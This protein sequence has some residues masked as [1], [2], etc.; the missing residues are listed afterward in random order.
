MSITITPPEVRNN[1]RLQNTEIAQLRGQIV[2]LKQSIMRYTGDSRLCSVAFASHKNYMTE[3]HGDF[4]NK[5]YEALTAFRRANDLHMR[6]ISADLASDDTFCS[7]QIQSEIDRL[8]SLIRT[9]ESVIEG[10]ECRLRFASWP[11]E[12]TNLNEQLRYNRGVLGKLE[13]L[14]EDSLDRQRRLNAYVANTNGLYLE[15][16]RLRAEAN[17][18]LVRI[19]STEFCK[20]TGTVSYM[21]EMT[22]V[23]EIIQIRKMVESYLD[24][25]G[26]ISD[27]LDVVDLFKRVAEGGSD[28][29]LQVLF[30][31]FRDHLELPNEI[32]TV[33]GLAGGNLEHVDQ[34]TIDASA[35]MSKLATMLSDQ[36]MRDTETHIWTGA[37]SYDDLTDIMRRA[38]LVT[39]LA[40]LGPGGSKV[41]YWVDLSQFADG[42]I[43]Y[44]GRPFEMSSTDSLFYGATDEALAA[45][46]SQGLSAN[47]LLL[48]A[49]KAVKPVGTSLTALELLQ[50]VSSHIQNDPT[51]TPSQRNNAF[52]DLAKVV[53]M[54]GGGKAFVETPSG[55]HVVG[56]TLSRQ[57]AM[58]NLAGVEQVLGI[59]QTEVFEILADPGHDRFDEVRR[60]VLGRGGSLNAFI[61]G[62]DTPSDVNNVFE[63]PVP[64]L[65]VILGGQ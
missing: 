63:I 30:L 9:T 12:I 18:F 50:L 11:A 5:F 25:D 60:F 6:R 16:E 26:N 29:E 24:G 27:L 15:A 43:I 40:S 17:R 22:R 58:I 33:Y 8:G 38:Q 55:V 44:R 41:E 34:R 56:T 21:P 54:L 48:I 4:Y 10:I 65:E 2:R 35:L 45:L 39:F 49:L 57:Q 3:A 19:E 32:L 31:L 62:L 61:R 23:D 1:L 52:I 46:R 42:T 64:E 51:L 47:Q 28:L 59:P 37:V 53:Q 36:F 14:Y 20:A 13:P 7:V